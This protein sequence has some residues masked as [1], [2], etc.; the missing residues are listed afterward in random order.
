MSLRSAE[1][2]AARELTTKVVGQAFHM[3]PQILGLEGA[4]YASITEY[5]RQLYTNVLAPRLHFLEQG[6]AKQLLI[7][8]EDNKDIYCEF[9]LEAKLRGSFQEQANIAVA[10][11]GGKAWMTVGEWRARLNLPPLDE[12]DAEAL[13]PVPVPDSPG[14]DP[15]PIEDAPAPSDNQM[16]MRKAERGVAKRRDESAQRL[17]KIVGKQFDRYRPVVAKGRKKLTNRTRWDRELAQDLRPVMELI[18]T[19]EATRKATRLGGDYDPKLHQHYLDEVAKGSAKG[20]NNMVDQ[21]LEV[22]ADDPSA[23]FEE[24]MPTIGAKFSLGLATGLFSFARQEAA[25]QNGGGSKTW[26]VTSSRSRHPEMNGETVPIGETFS[27][28]HDLPRL[29]R[30]RRV[31]RLSV[32][33]GRSA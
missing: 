32:R 27:N 33:N 10:A 24:A 31:G 22:H 3:S 7:E 6:F 29:G 11:L 21:T 26:I 15:S 5:N 30:R 18:V 14:P 13:N 25:K 20:L 2:V 1:Y 19:S 12:A 9:S 4:P 28:G 8:Y 23:A 16:S 17:E